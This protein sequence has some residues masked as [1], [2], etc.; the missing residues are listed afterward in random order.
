MYLINWVNYVLFQISKFGTIRYQH[1]WYPTFVNILQDSRVCFFFLS[2]FNR[3]V[4][5]K[6]YI[7]GSRQKAKS[8]VILLLPLWNNWIKTTVLIFEKTPI[9]VAVVQWG[10]SLYDRWFYLIVFFLLKVSYQ[11]I[12]HTYDWK[13]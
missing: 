3:K 2:F 10:V 12:F 8:S 6:P 11:Y 7:S 13:L 5:S 4:P 1:G 9:P